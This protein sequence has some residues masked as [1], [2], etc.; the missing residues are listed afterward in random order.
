MQA[1]RLSLLL[2]ALLLLGALCALVAAAAEP[3]TSPFVAVAESTWLGGTL[4]TPPAAAARTLRAWGITTVIDL[5]QRDEPGVA[6]EAKAFATAGIRHV[7]FPTDGSELGADRRADLAR[8]LQDTASER[9]LLHCVSG[10]R[11]ALAWAIHRIDEGASVEAALAEV[12]GVLT[13]PALVHLVEA[14][15]AARDTVARCAHAEC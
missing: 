13:R 15:A 9:R 14:H 12:D 4:T 5:R 7:S 1:A 11:A 8:L 2:L 6:D 10:N 3:P